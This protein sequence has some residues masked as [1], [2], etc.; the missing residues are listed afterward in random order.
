MKLMSKYFPHISGRSQERDVRSGL[1]TEA[2]RLRVLP[3]TLSETGLHHLWCGK[4]GVH[5]CRNVSKTGRFGGSGPPVA[6][7]SCCQNTRLHGGSKVRGS[8]AGLQMSLS[9]CPLG[10]FNSSKGFLVLH[11]FCS[12][13]SQALNC[14]PLGAA[15]MRGSPA[16]WLLS[17]RLFWQLK[18]TVR[19]LIPRSASQKVTVAIPCRAPK[20]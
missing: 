9:L 10:L 6:G 1:E 11:I 18:S 7:V 19:S 17:T 3:L 2:E 13:S 8:F 16:P 4:R 15:C 20:Y 12:L 5:R 14:F